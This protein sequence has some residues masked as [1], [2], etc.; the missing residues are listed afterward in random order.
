MRTI[1]SI[2]DDLRCERAILAF[3]SRSGERAKVVIDT[4]ARIDELLDERADA[5]REQELA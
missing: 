2:D 4:K 5:A 3:E 1:A